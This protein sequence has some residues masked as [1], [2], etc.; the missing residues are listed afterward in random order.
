MR[1]YRPACRTALGYG[2]VPGYSTRLQ[3]TATV[4]GHGPECRRGRGRLSHHIQRYCIGHNY[5]PHNYVG[6]NYIYGLQRES[7]LSVSEDEDGCRIELP[8]DR[9]CAPL[10]GTARLHYIGHNYIGHNYVGRCHAPSESSRRGGRFEYR[11]AYTRAIDHAVGD[12]RCWP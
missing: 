1:R 4:P 5:V 11:H 2:A 8:I 7:C 10:L 3:Y 12:G 9:L 6:H